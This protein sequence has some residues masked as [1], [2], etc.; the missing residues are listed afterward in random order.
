MKNNSLF[1]DTAYSF[2]LVILTLSLLNPFK[3]WM[4][5]MMTKFIIASVLIAFFFFSVFVWK[6]KIHDERE[7]S[8]AMLAGRIAFLSGTFILIVGI[9]YENF[10][11]EINPILVSALTVMALSKI[12]TLGYLQNKK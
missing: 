7:A 5:S 3:F 11:G 2:L 8:H 9:I 1:K 4:P 10:S 6:E 12:L